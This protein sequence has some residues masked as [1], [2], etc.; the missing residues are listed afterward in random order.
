M[1]FPFP[2]FLT[3]CAV[4]PSMPFTFCPQLT[5]LERPA[6][7]LF[8]IASPAQPLLP[9]HLLLALFIHMKFSPLLTLHALFHAGPLLPGWQLWGQDLC[10]FCHCLAPDS[11]Q[12]QARGEHSVNL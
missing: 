10:V 1:L 7:P 6:C 3:I 12:S 8:Q 4:P 2:E 9:P 5:S 11:G